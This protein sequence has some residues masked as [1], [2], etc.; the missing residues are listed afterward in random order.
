MPLLNLLTLKSK[1]SE[2]PL[3]VLWIFLSFYSDYQK[4]M[5]RK[6]M[7]HQKNELIQE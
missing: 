2:L 3:G 6:N 7:L 1:L 4:F 5:L